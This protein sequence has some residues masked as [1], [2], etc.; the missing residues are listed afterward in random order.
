[1][2]N[3]AVSPAWSVL[4]TSAIPQAR[5]ACV[6]CD[7]QILA[8]LVQG[9]IRGTGGKVVSG[10]LLR[11]DRQSAMRLPDPSQ[12]KAWQ[13]YGIA[14]IAS[15]L[16]VPMQHWVFVVGGNRFMFFFVAVLFSAW[17]CGF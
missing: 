15:A 7:K 1:M 10:K 9:P 3:W 13:R 8:M 4:K 11:V 2:N 16:A 12:L 17:F 6:P 14:L 5:L